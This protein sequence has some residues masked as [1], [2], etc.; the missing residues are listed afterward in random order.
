MAVPRGYDVLINGIPYVAAHRWAAARDMTAM[1]WVEDEA[2][3]PIQ[4]P[5]HDVGAYLS[6][7]R[8]DW[9]VESFRNWQDGAGQR[10]LDH[11]DA[12]RSRYH[13]SF[14]ID[15]SRQGALR[16][17]PAT[18]SLAE[19]AG[20]RPTAVACE[21]MGRVW[22]VFRGTDGK[23]ALYYYDQASDSWVL[24]GGA[25]P[26]DGVITA[27]CSDGDYVYFS[28][29]GAAAGNGVYKCRAGT[30]STKISSVQKITG[31]CVVAGYLC[32]ARDKVSGETNIPNGSSAGYLDFT[33]EPN[34]AY[35][36]CTPNPGSVWMPELSTEDLVEVDDSAYWLVRSA[37]DTTIGE[38]T[39]LFRFNPLSEGGG[40]SPVATFPT[41]FVGECAAAG[42]GE[43]YVGGYYKAPKVDDSGPSASGMGVIYRVIPGGTWERVVHIGEDELTDSRI[44]AMACYER[45]LYFVAGASLYRLAMQRG[46]YEHVAELPTGVPTTSWSDIEPS[47]WTDSWEGETDP[48]SEGWSLTP[49]YDKD[50]KLVVESADSKTYLRCENASWALF[51]KADPQLTGDAM[52]EFSVTRIVSDGGM[53][54][55]GNSSAALLTRTVANKVYQ[56]GTYCYVQ[57][58]RRQGGSFV[59][60][61]IGMW[62]AWKGTDPSG[63]KMVT[64]RLQLDHTNK[65]GVVYINGQEK[66]SIPYNQLPLSKP[67]FHTGKEEKT[68]IP[69]KNAV[70]FSVGSPINDQTVERERIYYDYVRYVRGQLVD[71]PPVTYVGDQARLIARYGS[72]FSAVSG[73]AVFRTRRQGESAY[74]T[75]GWL[76][77]SETSMGIDGLAK[78]LRYIDLRHEPLGAGQQIH[79]TPLVDGQS[80]ET[81]VVSEA[82]SPGDRQTILALPTG[83]RQQLAIEGSSVAVLIK[84]VGPGDSTPVLYNVTIRATIETVRRYQYILNCYDATPDASG[85]GVDQPYSGQVL[86]DNLRQIQGRSVEIESR[87]SG[88]YIGRIERLELRQG[89]DTDGSES[90]YQ[91]V[92]VLRIREL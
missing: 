31:M 9:Y 28:V 13:S 20:R 83:L 32:V 73:K 21:G 6:R 51:R 88:R 26:S 90:E 35:V 64:V 63:D 54:G 15:A 16:L 79:I 45:Y 48:Q 19:V 8:S 92:V 60:D 72:V 61:E 75:S 22:V 70:F 42:L 71:P 1:A 37:E 33:A 3:I 30:A 38:Q 4:R 55:I 14:C 89:I 66:R 23:D 67:I 12:N 39:R 81:F 85:S 59:W 40:F 49:R 7:D 11:A 80:Y 5:D 36:P 62:P 50:P 47:G 84:L 57:V 10:S 17:Q 46:G 76:R 53:Q 58:R 74:A 24:R 65:R 27:I 78:Y 56:G 91:G 82:S 25:H 69:L 68:A 18:V 41:G 2:E 87:I 77:T 29:T 43:V 44:F 52:M 34:R 86:I